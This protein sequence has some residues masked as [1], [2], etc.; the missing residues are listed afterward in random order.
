MSSYLADLIRNR[1]GRGV[2]PLTCAALFAFFAA[3]LTAWTA[4]VVTRWGSPFR[5]PLL[6]RAA[7]V[8]LSLGGSMSW[9][10]IN[11]SVEGHRV[12]A[13]THSHGL[14]TGDLWVV[15]ALAFAVALVAIEAGHRLRRA[16]L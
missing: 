10:W 5:W 6:H 13:L 2:S 4:F 7:L 1:A 15:P 8:T 3:T 16:V 12:L 9:W 11:G 14:T